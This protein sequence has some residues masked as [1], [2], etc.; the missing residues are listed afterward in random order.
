MN[1]KAYTI[2]LYEKAV[3][4]GLTWKAKLTA[5]KEA[6]YDFVEMSIDETNEKLARLDMSKEERFD[7]KPST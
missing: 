6:D 5:A 3:P 2:G 7:V 1:K 4:N